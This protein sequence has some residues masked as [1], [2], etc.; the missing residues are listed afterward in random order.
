ML[1]SSCTDRLTDFTVIS[2][3]N[4]PIGSGQP[5]EFSKSDKRIT[6]KDTKS[7][8]L[9]IPLGSPNLKQ[10]IDRAIESC[11]GAIGLADGVV[12]SKYFNAFFYGQASYV[13]EGTPIFPKDVLSSTTS[14]STTTGKAVTSSDNSSS[15]T[16]TLLF[17]HEVKA[18]EKLTDI[19]NNY[20]VTVADLIRW[21][22]LSSSNVPEGTKLKVHVK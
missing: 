12:K 17:Y 22:G 8:V 1:L 18:G 21:N 4:F 2:T 9:C 7:I 5:V 19:A 6:A 20:N 3:K 15:E 13:V 11:P 16:G 14:T 10:A